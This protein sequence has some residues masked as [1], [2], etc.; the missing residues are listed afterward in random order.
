MPRA[1]PR[2]NQLERAIN[3]KPFQCSDPRSGAAFV[4]LI[5]MSEGRASDNQ[6]LATGRDVLSKLAMTQN[7]TLLVA[8]SN[9]S[10][11]VV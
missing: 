2:Y 6:S 10:T 3:N 11:G 7:W 5:R 9:P 8:S 4:E 1:R